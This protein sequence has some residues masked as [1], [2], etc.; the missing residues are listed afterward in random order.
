M[1]LTT[2]PP[3]SHAI[4]P[5]RP[6][7]GRGVFGWTFFDPANLLCIGLVGTAIVRV[8]LAMQARND[9][10]LFM[11]ALLYAC[12][13]AFLRG[14]FFVYYHGS[15]LGLSVIW[16]V[17]CSGLLASAAFWQ[18]RAGA[19]TVLRDV[20]VT[21]P[22]EPGFQVAAVLHVAAVITLGLHFLMPRHWLMR[23]TD[24]VADRVG[25]DLGSGSPIE[26]LEATHRPQKKVPRQTDELPRE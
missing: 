8:V 4:K 19:V 6:R 9:P 21:L 2:L 15:R 14:Y 5:E 24:Q 16:L 3:G 22:P 26:Q 23:A 17:L 1:P 12:M 18:D 20:E 13:A 11:V 10:D 25:L 7:G